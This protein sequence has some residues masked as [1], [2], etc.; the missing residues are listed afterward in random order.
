MARFKKTAPG[1]TAPEGV[2][3][4]R[5]PGR[6]ITYWSREQ[7]VGAAWPK[8]RPH[9]SEVTKEQNEEFKRLV[10][11]LKQIPPD[12]RVACEQIAQ[13]SKYTW[14]DV[15]SLA[16]TARLCYYPNYGEKVAQYNLDIL[17]TEAGM[18]VMR[19]LEEWI[20]LSVGEEGQVLTVFNGLPAWQDPATPSGGGIPYHP[21]LVPGVK[22]VPPTPS[23]LTNATAL[24]NV[25]KATPFYVPQA[26]TLDQLTVRVNTLTVGA[27]ISLGIYG[28]TDG[29]P[30]ALLLDAGAVSAAT[31]GDKTITGVGLALSQQWI[32]I[33][34]LLSASVTMTHLQNTSIGSGVP[35]GMATLSNAQ[36]ANTHISRAQTY[37]T[38]ALPS[39][40]SPGN[41]WATGVVPAVGLTFV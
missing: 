25:L 33:A 3:G 41:N 36:G 20:A 1:L 16:M 15:A 8:T 26:T 28:T 17:G 37:G 11:A 40:F 35:I 2:F 27:S 7:L 14:R 38:G 23:A 39:P 32:W 9:V 10:F 4:P 12:M 6:F 19:T 31:T 22:Y 30:D 21:G 29:L 13:G 34:T 18:I 24:A 5:S